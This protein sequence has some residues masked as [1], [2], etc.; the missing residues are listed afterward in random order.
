[1]LSSSPSA[2]S[3]SNGGVFLR[4]V[5]VAAA[6]SSVNG[7]CCVFLSICVTAEAASLPPSGITKQ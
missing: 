3:G 2:N 6:F 4:L 7:G 1:R 5:L